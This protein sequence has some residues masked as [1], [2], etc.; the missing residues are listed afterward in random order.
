MYSL[1]CRVA[2]E[3]ICCVFTSYFSFDCCKTCG[4]GLKP[5]DE[6]SKSNPQGDN[7]LR[8]LWQLQ[9]CW[10]L[11][12]NQT[13]EWGQ[14]IFPLAGI[15][16]GLHFL[17]VCGPKR[18][19]WSTATTHTAQRLVG[20]HSCSPQPDSWTCHMLWCWVCKVMSY[21]S[22]SVYP[23]PPSLLREFLH[24]SFISTL[25]I[26]LH[27]VWCAFLTSNLMGMTLFIMFS[28]H[29][30]ASSYYLP[31]PASLLCPYPLFSL[32]PWHSPLTP[33]SL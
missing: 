20:Q 27:E 24:S 25:H 29:V 6:L 18:Q 1:V 4:D 14:P 9:P 33:Q 30:L 19:M 16:L 17:R 32:L 13:L 10:E 22:H 26:T 8:F 2:V 15:Y 12:K 28:W 31:L 21:L 7:E 23:L 11:E 5:Q 3:H